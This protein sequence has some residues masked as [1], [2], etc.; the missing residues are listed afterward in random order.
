VNGAY[1]FRRTW[2]SGV[3][4]W[5]V[6]PL[7][8]ILLGSAWP[9]RQDLITMRGMRSMVSNNRIGF[10]NRPLLAGALQRTVSN[11][12]TG[13]ENAPISRWKSR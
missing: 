7:Q 12:W 8:R 5:L 6:I 1:G 10:E 2:W 4:T 11:N 3:G 13:L 9:L